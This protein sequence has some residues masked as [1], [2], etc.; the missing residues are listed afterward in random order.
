[1]RVFLMLDGSPTAVAAFLATV[2]SDLSVGDAAGSIPTL[3]NVASPTPMQALPIPTMP[4]AAILPPMPVGD[5]DDEDGPADAAAPTVDKTGLP[6]DERIHAK[7]KA[8]NADGSWRKKKGVH[9]TTVTVVEAELRGVA[10]QPIPAPVPVAMPAVAMPAV[11]MPAPVATPMA[12]AM[13]APAPVPMPTMMPAAAPAPMPVPMPAP[14][15]VIS[16]PEPGDLDAFMP[17]LTTQMQGGV[18][19]PDDLMSLVATVNAA[20]APHGLQPVAAI[21]DLLG[22]TNRL[23]YAVQVL[24]SQGKW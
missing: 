24:Q 6:W 9:E 7:N 15:P 18:I 17:H 20:F 19:T 23:P 1:M 2:P 4:G 21:T 8:T 3:A 5:G 13:P 12:A 22:D 11:A 14:A 16:A 10:P